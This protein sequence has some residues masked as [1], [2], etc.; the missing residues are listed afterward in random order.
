MLVAPE[1]Q[2]RGQEKDAGELEGHG[3]ELNEG[4]IEKSLNM[5]ISILTKK[6]KIVNKKVGWL[7]Y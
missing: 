4:K 3:I 6:A 5:N 7:F 1:R 2:N